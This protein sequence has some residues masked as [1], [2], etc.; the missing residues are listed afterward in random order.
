VGLIAQLEL[1]L[2]RAAFEKAIVQVMWGFS[3]QINCRCGCKQASDATGSTD[4]CWTE[5]CWSV[6]SLLMMQ[7][8][9]SALV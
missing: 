9:M 7:W 1:Q 4:I 6:F 2:A 5:G 8:L 3:T